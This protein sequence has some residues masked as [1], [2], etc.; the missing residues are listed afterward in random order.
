MLN[1]TSGWVHGT[2][3]PWVSATDNLGVV[4][5]QFKLDG[6]NLGAELTTLPYRLSWNTSTV[7]DGAQVLTAVARDAAG[8]TATSAPVALTIDNTAP[9]LTARTPAVGGDGGV[10]VRP[11]RDGDVQR[12]RPAGDDLD[13]VEE[14][15]QPGDRRHHD[16]RPGGAG[17]RRSPRWGASTPRRSTPRRSA[18]RGTPP[19]TRSPP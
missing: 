14:C 11:A 8:T 18:A 17:G 7:A 3:V 6:N 12:G 10:H 2:I 4:G 19:A 9:T 16:L 5:V 13:R 1:P 15:V